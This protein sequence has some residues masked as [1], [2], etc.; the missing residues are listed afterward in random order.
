MVN[1]KTEYL[2]DVLFYLQDGVERMLVHS[3]PSTSS[4]SKENE[5][6]S[7]QSEEIPPTIQSFCTYFQSLV[8]RDVAG[9]DYSFIQKTQY[10]RQSFIYL[11]DETFREDLTTTTPQGKKESCEVQQFPSFV[12]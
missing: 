2:Q 8:R 10:N 3:G 12:W 5:L 4:N 6:S 1:G 11:C 9:R 7:P